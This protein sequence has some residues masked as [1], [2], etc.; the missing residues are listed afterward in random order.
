MVTHGYDFQ[1]GHNLKTT[2]FEPNSQINLPFC[3]WISVPVE[4]VIGHF[5][6]KRAL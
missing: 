2:F 6:P 4:S 1:T 3:G 5:K